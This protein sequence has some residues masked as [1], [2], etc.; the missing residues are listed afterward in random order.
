MHTLLS[1]KESP[2]SY[3]K[4]IVFQP[5]IKKFLLFKKIKISDYHEA[6]NIWIRRL[7]KCVNTRG[8]IYNCWRFNFFSNF[9]IKL[10]KK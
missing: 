8:E 1:L 6:F 9:I 2:D 10:F 3:R 7:Q 4:F 5:I